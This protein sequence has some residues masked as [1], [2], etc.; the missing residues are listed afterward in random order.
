M[1]TNQKPWSSALRQDNNNHYNNNKQHHH[2]QQQYGHQLSYGQSQ[3]QLQ[4]QQRPRIM[5]TPINKFNPAELQQALG[6]KFRQLE[7]QAMSG[8]PG[9]TKLKSTA[10]PQH[11]SQMHSSSTGWNTT[12]KSVKGYRRGGQ[13]YGGGVDVLSELNKSF[14][15]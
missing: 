7:E 1:A 3:Q 10:P 8:K 5:Y 13:R 2:Q 15:S 4:Q 9:I 12:Y 14:E 6:A 11:Q